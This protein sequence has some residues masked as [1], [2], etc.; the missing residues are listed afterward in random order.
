MRIT[1]KA[2]EKEIDDS[3]SRHG[4][5]IQFDIMDLGKIAD[6]GR[7]AV[8]SGGLEAIDEAVKNAIQK[9]RKN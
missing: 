5:N 9:Y 4:Q 2:I 1:K 3:F 8:A 6:A 7:A